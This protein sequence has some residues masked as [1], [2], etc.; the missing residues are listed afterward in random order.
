MA[1]FL[2]PDK[3]IVVRSIVYQIFLVLPVQKDSLLQRLPT[4]TTLIKLG[5]TVSMKVAGCPELSDMG[6]KSDHRIRFSRQPTWW[7]LPTSN[8]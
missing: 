1:A 8:L 2:F 6:L 4:A 5:S 7:V 3:M